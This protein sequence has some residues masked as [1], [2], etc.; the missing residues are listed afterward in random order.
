MLALLALAASALSAC[1][2]APEPTP[3][4]TA[5]FASEEE[6]FAA[7]EE[8]YRAYMDAFNEVHYEDSSTFTPLD[9]FTSGDYQATEREGLS[10]MHAEGNSRTGETLISWFRG[11]NFEGQ[12]TI[13]ARA[14]NDVSGVSVVDSQ[15]KSLISP[16]RPPRSAVDLTFAVDEDARVTLVNAQGSEDPEC[17]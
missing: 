16:D 7:A 12:E 8:V 4:P 10:Q 1:T 14:C 5:A 17:T 13:D 15:G 6:A 2:P 3:T 9:E 11:V